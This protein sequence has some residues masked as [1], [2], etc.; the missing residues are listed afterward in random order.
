MLKFARTSMNR[1]QACFS[2]PVASVRSSASNRQE[3]KERVRGNI[4]FKLYRRPGLCVHSK[5]LLG[6]LREASVPVAITTG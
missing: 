3:G 6:V 5:T 4:W 1:M 2:P